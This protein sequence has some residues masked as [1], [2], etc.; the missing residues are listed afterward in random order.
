MCFSGSWA[1]QQGRFL[2]AGQNLS[3]LDFSEMLYFTFFAMIFIKCFRNSMLLPGPN[4]TS[5][6]LSYL[7]SMNFEFSQFFG[8][9]TIFLD[10]HNFLT[11][12]INLFFRSRHSTWWT[13]SELEL[14]LNLFE[15]VYTYPILFYR[16][17]WCIV[18]VDWGQRQGRIVR[19][20]PYFWR[21][22]QIQKIEGLE[23]ISGGSGA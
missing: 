21:R 16:I 19:W 12:K 18:K 2:Y 23:N 20:R 9:F 22:A 1:K 13:I 4:W 10:F 11:N 3:K 5:E 6:R 8:I 7:C 17:M 14:F 15:L